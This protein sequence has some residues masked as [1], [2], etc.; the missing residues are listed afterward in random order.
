MMLFS[1]DWACDAIGMAFMAGLLI[2]IVNWL[3]LLIQAGYRRLFPA[4]STRR[5]WGITQ[6]LVLLLFLTAGSVL[7]AH[8]LIPDVNISCFEA[9][10]NMD[11]PPEISD[12]YA[13]LHYAG[14]PEDLVFVMKFHAPRET[15]QK[16]IAHRG[17]SK[18]TDLEDVFSLEDWQNFWEAFMGIAFDYEPS[19]KIVPPIK[20]PE[21]YGYFIDNGHDKPYGA[22]LMWDPDT[23]QTYVV[24]TNG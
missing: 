19:W 9:A 18:N 13:D 1:N 12:L 21:I 2:T 4:Q 23:E 7:Y 24:Y 20:H 11:P 22:D 6:Q 17:M 16:L 5:F 15:I 10:F 3:A 14:G 8:E